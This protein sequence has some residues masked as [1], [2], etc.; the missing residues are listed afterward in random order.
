VS[1]IREVIVTA[2]SILRANRSPSTT[3]RSEG[4]DE[5]D[6]RA[7]SGGEIDE[8]SGEEVEEGTKSGDAP[9]LE[10]PTE[11]GKPMSSFTL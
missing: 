11:K 6:L 8:D 10:L 2:S 1:D 4:P 9:E 5:A 7:S 3:P